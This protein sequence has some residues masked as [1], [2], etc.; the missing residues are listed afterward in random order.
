MCVLSLYFQANSV[1]ERLTQCSGAKGEKYQMSVNLNTANR[2]QQFF[3]VVF[4]FC[5]LLTERHTLDTNGPHVLLFIA[6]LK[7]WVQHGPR[8]RDAA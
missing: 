2:V 3:F 4:F 1:S 6:A 7:R 5:F 8:R